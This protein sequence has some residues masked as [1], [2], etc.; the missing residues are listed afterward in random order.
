MGWLLVL[1]L[2]ALAGLSPFV[3]RLRRPDQLVLHQSGGVVRQRG[4]RVYP[5][6]FSISVPATVH[7][8]TVE[9]P[10]ETRGH[11]AVDV[12]LALSVAPHP[13]HLDALVRAGGWQQDAVTRAAKELEIA[14]TALVG[15]FVE[16]HDIDAL[17]RDELGRAVQEALVRSALA[18][19]LEV[20]GCNVQSVAAR[21][22][23]IS[24]AFRRREEARVLELSQTAEQEARVAATQARVAADE[25]IAALE[26]GLAV[27]RLAL[28]Q[29]EEDREAALARRRVEEENARRRLQLEIDRQ[30]VE[31][32]R[33]SPELLILTP[34]VARLA[35]AS[36]S[37][38]NARTVV[39]LT[40]AGDGEAG[41]LLK[42]LLSLVERAGGGVAP[43]APP[44]SSPAPRPP[45]APP[46]REV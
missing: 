27:Q 17:S 15:G 9:V 8:T 18:L 14:V 20:V 19:G 1:V 16:Q 24:E 5:R 36:Q 11:L 4:W 35:E 23:Q 25:R 29:E 28:R 6:H 46:R 44:T 38:R 33:S 2:L 31:L 21:D 43:A 32:L 41:P 45:A 42:A 13:A 37:L 26:H 30:E 3:L 22:P 39:S 34:Q 12:Q 40:G 7:T 10:T